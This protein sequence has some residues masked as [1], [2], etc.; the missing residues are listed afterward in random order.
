MIQVFLYI[1]AAA[2]PVLVFVFLVIFHVPP[3][4]FSLFIISVALVSF[5]GLTSKKKSVL[6]GL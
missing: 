4:F 5:L 3:R 1:L 2:Y 6:S